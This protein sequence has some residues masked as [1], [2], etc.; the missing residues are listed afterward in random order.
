M[1]SIGIEVEQMFPFI[2]QTGL[3]C[4]AFTELSSRTIQSKVPMS[5]WMYGCMSVAVA[6]CVDEM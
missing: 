3:L 4:L 2:V 5:V 6:V 1:F